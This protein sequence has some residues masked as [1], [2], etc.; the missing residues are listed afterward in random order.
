M[1]IELEDRSTEGRSKASVEDH[2]TEESKAANAQEEAAS[3][4]VDILNH[5]TRQ[6]LP[7]VK[8][9]HKKRKTDK[10]LLRRRGCLCAGAM[11][12]I[13]AAFVLIVIAVSTSRLTF[14]EDEEV[15]RSTI[16]LNATCASGSVRNTLFPLLDPLL[17][18]GI[19]TNG[20]PLPS[21]FC[22]SWGFP[23]VCRSVCE[24]DALC[25]AYAATYEGAC[26]SFKLKQA[27][28]ANESVM[29]V[30]RGWVPMAKWVG[31]DYLLIESG[32]RNSK[33]APFM[34]NAE[35]PC[36]DEGLVKAPNFPP[37]WPLPRQWT[38][39]TASLLVAG[40][41]VFDMPATT[42]VPATLSSAFEYYR[43]L[44]FTHKERERERSVGALT[45]E[46]TR[47]ISR[48]QV[49]VDLLSEAHPQQNTDESYTLTIP[50]TNGPRWVNRQP[51]GLT[52]VGSITASLS[53][54]TVYGALHGLETLSQLIYYDFD[55]GRYRLDAAPWHIDDKPRFTHR[56]LLLDTARHFQPVSAIKQLIDSLSF[57]KMNLLHWHLTDSESFPLEFRS[58]PEL[59]QGSFSNR[60]RY[61][62][63][64][65]EEVVEHA[66][67]RGVRVIAE[68]DMPGHTAS[69]CKGVPSVCSHTQPLD[70]NC[71]IWGVLNVASDATY[72]LVE[73]LLDELL[74]LFPDELIHL[75]GDE[76]D[77]SCWMKTPAVKTWLDEQNMNATEAYGYFVRRV[78]D[79]AIAK[80]RR[81]VHW[82]EV[83]NHFGGNITSG[84]SDSLPPQ[85][86]V[87]VWKDPQTLAR[88]VA[89]GHEA[90]LSNSQDNAAWNP[91]RRVPH[92]AG[93]VWYL[94]Y[95]DVDWAQMY[96]VEPCADID[97][98][99]DCARFVLGGEGALWGTQVDS[100][101]LMQSAWPRLA[102]IA[103]RLWSNRSSKPKSD[104]AHEE[105][106]INAALPRLEAFRC[107]LMQRGVAVA[108]VRN[109]V[110]RGAPQ[111][112]ASC[113]D[114][115]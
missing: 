85:E 115:R 48:V 90:I 77:T 59:W 16:A 34:R 54:K 83:F 26:Y 104:P 38:N 12:A 114:L 112:P 66:R 101:D 106:A 82:V 71:A 14:D 56:G 49:Q 65:V 22:T 10:Q 47:T 64:D 39:G 81:P 58:H 8:P 86:V 43:A 68:L 17:F 13:A 7:A 18:K 44:T 32:V 110:A 31:G 92:G 88:V 113:A 67:L 75:G 60:E 105:A 63:S 37:V 62:Q 2:S 84:T 53:A 28:A 95:N 4:T 87:H 19:G 36:L 35:F 46:L 89:A 99:E 20:L 72:A 23:A 45:D 98:D 70:V 15:K 103:E 51:G 76:V 11:I 33:A 27:P 5:E 50:A 24:K 1:K 94:D 91:L 41:L 97:R 42:A 78:A 74:L 25:M 55:M 80:G 3:D 21:V 93:R 73:D 96:A 79:M 6:F 61:S 107:L 9:A 111:G 108:P 100:S 30:H 69:W 52:Q 29:H 40:A 109:P 102:A 57:A